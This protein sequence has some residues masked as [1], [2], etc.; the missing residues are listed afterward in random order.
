MSKCKYCGEYIEWAYDVDRE[1]D[2][3][4][5][6][7]PIDPETGERHQCENQEIFKKCNRCGKPIVLRKVGS[8]WKPFDEGLG[9]IHKCTEDGDDCS[10]GV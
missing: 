10:G 1:V 2:G 3:R 9:I 5:G 4:S 8:K 6:W 7:V